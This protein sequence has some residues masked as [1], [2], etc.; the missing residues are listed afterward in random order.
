MILRRIS[1]HVKEQN[2]TAIA[3]DFVIVVMGVALGIQ[4]SNWNEGRKSAALEGRYLD[5][6]ADD[7]QATVAGFSEAMELTVQ[8]RQSIADFAEA[9]ADPST[10][11]EDLVDATNRLLTGG[12]SMPTFLPVT[13]AF[14]DLASTGTLDVIR[15]TQLRTSIIELHNGFEASEKS[16]AI[17]EGWVLPNDTRIIYDYDAL[18]WDPRT[19][20]L[21]PERSQQAAAADVRQNQEHLLR[22]AASHY[23]LKDR[24]IEHYGRA[25]EQSRSVLGLL[26]SRRPS[27]PSGSAP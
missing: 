2:W 24:A 20:F 13:V 18:R 25:I 4:V 15:D 17:N 12:W 26:E 3:I 6:I 23:W 14:D 9:L 27:T 16:F 5:R 1:Q 21:Y 10:S 7:L 11:D 22:L 8:R 19:S